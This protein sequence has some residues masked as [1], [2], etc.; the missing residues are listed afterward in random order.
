VIRN[1][2]AVISKNAG[3]I[4]RNRKITAVDNTCHFQK[5]DGNYLQN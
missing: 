5:L 4:K 2:D 1:N 3:W